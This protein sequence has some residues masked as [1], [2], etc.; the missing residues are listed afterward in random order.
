MLAVIIETVNEEYT[1][2]I[3]EALR[4][5]RVFHDIKQ[6]DLA[7]KFNIPKSRLSEIENSKKEASLDLIQLY[8]TEF[9]IPLSAILF[10]AEELPN[11][12]N[13]QKIKIKIAT[14]ILDLLKFIER[15]SLQG[16]TL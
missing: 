11:A 12:N 7:N 16:E 5:I 13:G 14:K 8:A 9:N 10:F 3:N 2:M 4:L 1:M 15:K 6:S